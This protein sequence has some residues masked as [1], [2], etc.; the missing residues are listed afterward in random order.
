MGFTSFM[1]RGNDKVKGE[2]KLVSIAH[3]IRKI[4]LYLKDQRKNMVDILTEAGC[5]QS[6]PFFSIIVI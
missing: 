5:R 2:F 4:W 6:L 3:N 1:I